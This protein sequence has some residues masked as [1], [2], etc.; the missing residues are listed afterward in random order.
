M[1]K[2]QFLASCNE[3]I[4]RE[5][6]NLYLNVYT[7]WGQSNPLNFD[8][9]KGS[10]TKQSDFEPTF[11][12]F[13]KNLFVGYGT[14]MNNYP[15]HKKLDIGYAVV[16]ELRRK[17][18]GVKICKQ[19]IKFAKDKFNPK[20]IVADVFSG[21]IGSEKVLIKN[22]FQRVGE[23]PNF[24]YSLDHPRSVIFYYLNVK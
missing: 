13:N 10:Y 18:Y 9:F 19:L 12:F 16:P 20:T 15:Q 22:G 1:I 5:A 23:I 8:E 6:F 14:I 3:E 7:Q 11:A 21:N 24:N 17:G 2:K 4:V